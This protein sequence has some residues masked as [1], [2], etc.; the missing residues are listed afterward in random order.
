[1]IKNF[2]KVALRNISRNRLYSLI[3]IAGLAIGMASA[4]LILFWVQDELSYDRF[5][6]G[7]NQLYRV[8]WDFKWNGNEGVGPGTPPPLAGKLMNEVPGIESA[9]RV[10]P[11]LRTVV[12]NGSQFFDEDGIVSADSNFLELFP[13]PIISGNPAT[14]LKSP[15]SVVLTESAAR[16]Y[17]GNESPMGKNLVIGQDEKNHYGVY[18]SLFRVTGVVKDPPHNSHIRFNMLTSM[19]SY[20]EV[21][22]RDWSW[23]WMQLATYV[24]LKANV[25]PIAVQSKIPEIE[26][27]Y[28]PAGL[29]RLGY[30][31]DDMIKSG[32]HWHFVLQPVT[33]IYLGSSLTGNRLGPLGDRTEVYLMSVI[34]VLILLIAS[35][36]FMNLTTAR[37]GS[38]S[39][40]IGVRK[41]LGS[42]RKALVGQF[43]VESTLFSLLSLAIAVFL[44]EMFMPLFN[45][46]TGKS[47]EF[48]L[49]RSWWL[50]PT[51]LLLGTVVG[52]ASGSYPGFY[53][54]ALKPAAVMKGAAGSSSRKSAL[55]NVLVVAQF[56]IAIGLIT[57]TLLV[58]KQMDFVRNMNL[59]FNSNDVVAISN[60]NERLGNR[61]DAF[62]D[63]LKTHSQVIDA[64]ISTGVP[65]SYGF[66]DGYEIEGK[67][68]KQFDL[69]S[70][71]TD[72]DFINTM[73]LKIVE[74]RGFEKGYSDS[75]SVVLNEAAVKY[76]GFSHPIGEY[77]TYVSNG[78]K[79]NVIGVVKDFNFMTLY[80]P[81]TPFALFHHSSK[82]YSIPNSFVVVR[83][84]PDDIQGTISMLKSEWQAFAPGM[85]FEYTF[86]DDD[87][88]SGYQ[89]AMRLG[90]VFLVFSALTV[91][92][93]CLGL[94]A[95]AAFATE[96]RTK[97]IGIRK[98]LGA[99]VG[100]I[101]FMLSKEF[102]KWIVIANVIAWPVAYFV[103]NSWLRN[104]AY[105]T[106]VPLWIFLISGLA[107]LAIALA[108]VS[109]HA[110]RAAVADP[111]ESLRYE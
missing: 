108:T 15:N 22:W 46:L 98:V 42:E 9:T 86:V 73:G 100:E 107:A 29:K 94:F 44:V 30:S 80:S 33:D 12:R 28:L 69:L 63:L 53:L 102:L 60:E 74:G 57:C 16:K 6:P 20:P 77:V 97:E 23:V 67:Q 55:R 95:L 49:F 8:N 66:E 13:F 105:R 21:A 68:E 88:A 10:R 50:S 109:W 83:M 5:I 65:P 24:R 79:Y 110:V 81:I 34:A 35:I 17:F 1:M 45:D 111:V 25:P 99:S 31:Y 47:L 76:L 103:M 75:A 4:I 27:K 18:Q 37:S 89:P 36:N 38:R 90:N 52:I 14:A 19:S 3:S 41:V 62:R 71:M 39:K 85:P 92:I 78:V 70:Y 43:L 2:L 51:L 61:A 54:S 58:K 72:D 40:E 104:F 59:G 101:L 56:T 11:M 82:S 32:G 87:F 96:Q 26:S 106:S 93:A 91:F 84:R 7:V 64:S 48:N